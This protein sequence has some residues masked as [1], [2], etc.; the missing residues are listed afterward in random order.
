MFYTSRKGCVCCWISP[1]VWM[2]ALRATTLLFNL[3]KSSSTDSSDNL[4][5]RGGWKMHN[6]NK[7][8]L[9]NRSHRNKGNKRMQM[10]WRAPTKVWY[11]LLLKRRMRLK[12][13]R[14]LAPCWENLHLKSFQQSLNIGSEYQCCHDPLS[15]RLKAIANS[16]ASFS[17]PRNAIDLHYICLSSLLGSIDVIKQGLYTPSDTVTVGSDGIWALGRDWPRGGANMA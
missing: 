5:T 15:L 13:V 11:S 6:W 3:D 7:K 2:F 4:P 17:D 10:I 16:W 14:S 8:Q 1:S 9:C 12:A